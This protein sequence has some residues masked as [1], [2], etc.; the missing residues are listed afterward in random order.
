ME[1]PSASVLS[2]V[3]EQSKSSPTMGDEGVMAIP[4]AVG[5]VLATVSVLLVTLVVSS[6]SSAVTTTKTS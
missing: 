5:G 6:P 3:T 1:S 4:G 2:D